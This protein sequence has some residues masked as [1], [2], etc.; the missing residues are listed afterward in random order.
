MSRYNRYPVSGMT[1]VQIYTGT[2]SIQYRD[3]T[4]Y[5]YTAHPCLQSVVID[6][7]ID[8][9][10]YLLI[11]IYLLDAC[12]PFPSS[13]SLLVQLQTS[14][15]SEAVWLFLWCNTCVSNSGVCSQRW[16]LQGTAEMQALWWENNSKSELVL[17]CGL[18]YN[19][20]IKSAAQVIGNYLIMFTHFPCA[21]EHNQLSTEFCK[22]VVANVIHSWLISELWTHFCG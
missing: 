20:V 5:R 2:V 13:I 15:Y 8:S 9:A 21:W 11:T 16:T 12:C 3:T 14:E 1:D 6:W 4:T 22:I 18:C 7:W 19:K 17:L 10:M